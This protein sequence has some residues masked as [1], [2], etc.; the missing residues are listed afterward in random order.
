MARKKSKKQKKRKQ[1][2]RRYPNQQMVYINKKI[3]HNKKGYFT[4]DTL[5]TFEA[6][7]ILTGTAFKMYIYLSQFT[8][9]ATIYL[10]G[11]NFCKLSG[12]TGPTYIAAKKDLIDN[13]YLILREDGDF[14]FYNEPIK[15][16]TKKDEI[17]EGILNKIKEENA[18]EEEL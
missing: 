2:D 9:G 17:M 3:S 4:I 15:I 5:K 8:N 6:M 1:Q 10:S 16:P 7:R 13:H 14:D 12:I 11:N 18:L